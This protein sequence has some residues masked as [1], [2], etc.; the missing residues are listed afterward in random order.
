MVDVQFVSDF[1]DYKGKTLTYKIIEIEPSENR[2]ILSR[3]AVLEA[4]KEVAKKKS[5][6]KF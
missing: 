6:I 4:E 5:W 2:L 3:R 1:S